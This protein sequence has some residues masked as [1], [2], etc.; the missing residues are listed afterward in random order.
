MLKVGDIVCG[1]KDNGFVITNNL[2][3]MEVV[4]I[5]EETNYNG[6]TYNCIDVKVLF[7]A[8]HKIATNILYRNI[9]G[10]NIFTGLL[11]A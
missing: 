3:I 7:T 2:A 8:N 4:D 6:D 10:I 11:E 5:Y 1:N 9:L